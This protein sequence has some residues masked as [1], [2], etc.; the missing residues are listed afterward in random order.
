[1]SIRPAKHA[2]DAS[3][4]PFS[5]SKRRRIERSQPVRFLI[6][7]DTHGVDLPKNLPGCD[8]VL[9]CGD[10]TEDGR[11]ESI[12]AALQA[13]G[14]IEAKLKLVIAGNHEISLDKAYWS[15]QGGAE[16]DVEWAHALISPDPS[17][18]ASINGVTFLSE[19]THTFTLPCDATFSIY[20]SP[21]TPAYLRYGLSAFQYPSNEDRFN[22]PGVTPSWA[23][24]TATEA[25][26]IPNGVDIVMT[27]GPSKYVLDLTDDDISAGCE[28]LRRAIARVKPRLHCFGH[29]HHVPR[30][31]CYEAHRL[32]YGGDSELDGD[33][34]SIRSV[35]KDYVGNNQARKNGFR[36]L[37]PG[38]AQAFRDSKQTLCVN[39]AMEGEKGVLEHPPWRV[40]LELDSSVPSLSFLIVHPQPNKTYHNMTTSSSLVPYT[41]STRPTSTSLIPARLFTHQTGTALATQLLYRLLFDFLN[42]LLSSLHRLAS[43]RMTSW[44]DCKLQERRHRHD[45]L[46]GLQIVNEVGRLQGFVTCPLSGRGLDSR[47]KAW[48]PPMWVQGVLEGIESG[49]MVER[50]FWIHTHGD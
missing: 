13:L 20:A 3:S 2:R 21:Y 11:P 5:S 30:T 12:S 32:D 45:E 7:S 27:H 47:A 29:I 22:P 24:N 36:G 35:I 34:E 39:A 40:D 15:S 43:R 8:V 23:T 6:L 42:R 9:H 26:T 17:S 25:S 31:W 1:M 46:D 4:E 49:R 18:E 50:D 44:L 33:A 16:A 19:G 28:H 38:P 37:N 10:L 41:P 48:G 14:K